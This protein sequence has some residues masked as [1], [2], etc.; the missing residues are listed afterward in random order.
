MAATVQA[1]LDEDKQNILYKFKGW[2]KTKKRRR[3]AW[4]AIIALGILATPAVSAGL[5]DGP[6]SSLLAGLYVAMVGGGGGAVGVGVGLGFGR[7]VAIH[8]D[9]EH[10][11]PLK[12][13]PGIWIARSMGELEG[14]VRRL[15]EAPAGAWPDLQ[16]RAQNL[17]RADGRAGKRIIHA[18]EETVLQ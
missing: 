13:W 2:A 6:Y 10:I 9:W 4:V 1:L 8:E 3:N 5:A 16:A 15:V 17:A 14:H 11:T 18:V 12:S 7:G